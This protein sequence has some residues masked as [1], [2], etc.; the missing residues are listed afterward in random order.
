MS[1]T[2]TIPLNTT[3]SPFFQSAV[4]VALNTVEPEY[5]SRLGGKALPEDDHVGFSIHIIS[6]MN[7]AAGV[8]FFLNGPLVPSNWVGPMLLTGCVQLI[9]WFMIETILKKD[10]ERARMI[11]IEIRYGDW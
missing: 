11:P 6:N 4:E 7:I 8:F 10:W 2:T 9:T 5:G 1:T 3:L